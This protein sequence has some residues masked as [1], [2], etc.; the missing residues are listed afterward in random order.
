MLAV[1]VDGSWVG[2]GTTLEKTNT[3]CQLVTVLVM[4][5][6]VVIIHHDQQASWGRKSLF[7]LLFNSGHTLPVREVRAKIQGRNLE[8]KQSMEECCLLVC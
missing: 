6:I 2:S 8:L 1:Q 4:D 5:S 7:Y 3:V